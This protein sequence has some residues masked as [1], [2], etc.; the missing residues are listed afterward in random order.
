MPLIMSWPGHFAQGLQTEALVELT[1]IAPTL[2]EIAHVDAGWTHG[3]SL[4]PILTGQTNGHDHRDFVRC[5]FYDVLDMFW[6]TG[7]PPP[8]PSYAT[9][10]R[11]RQYKLV[12]YHGN[13]YGEL[14]DLYEDPD[15]HENMW[16]D[17]VAQDLK[18]ELIK[19]SFD[20]SIV[21]HDPGST[22]IGRF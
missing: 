1:D 20:A 9:M 15:E 16:E 12:V 10:H 6:N 22:R 5:E 2:C 3:K 4:V 7:Q 13:A 19:A 14:Y 21:I 17:E 8:P 11:T 18:H